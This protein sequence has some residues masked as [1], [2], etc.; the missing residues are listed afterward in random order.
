MDRAKVGRFGKYKPFTIFSIFLITISVCALFN[1]PMTVSSNLVFATIWIIFFYLCFDVGGSLFTPNLIYRTLTLDTVQRGKLMIGPRLV[2][3][4]VGMLTTAVIAI[5]SIINENIG[6]M[7][8][9]FGLTVV[10]IA[11]LLGLVSLIGIS[12]VKEKYHTP[13]DS[14]DERVRLTDIFRIIKENK[15]LRTKLLSDVFGGLVWTFLFA[16]A[17]YY[18]KWSY[19]TDLSTG[20]VDTARFGTLSMIS[21]MIMFVP[22]LLGTILSAPLLKKIGS[23][24]T[25]LRICI[26][27]QAIPCGILF[28]LQIIGILNT[29]PVL[30]FACLVVTSVGIGCVF[31]PGET[32]NIECMDYLIFKTGRDRSALCNACN[33]FLVKAQSAISVGVIGILLTSI[34]YVVDSATDTFLGDLAAIPAMLTWFI[35]IMGLI[36][37]LLGII[38]WAILRVYPIN[39]EIRA[40]MKS[41][42]NK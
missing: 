31:I 13:V 40:E 2:G 15:A 37:F 19:C 35:V 14:S 20:V 18:I 4:M 28:I 25:F 6:N 36:P 22:L 30:F 24:V 21:A 29:M 16:T 32:I 26:L 23:P 9:S 17:T 11:I 39:N 5:A 38:A 3:M 41:A 7:H 12:M 27:T 34:G 10:V 42:L 8:T 1:M 33:R